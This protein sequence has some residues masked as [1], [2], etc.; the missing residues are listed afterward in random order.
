MKRHIN[1]TENTVFFDATTGFT[2]DCS[3]F[4]NGSVVFIGEDAEG[5]WAE[6]DPFTG[7]IRNV[8]SN[9]IESFFGTAKVAYEEYQKSIELTPAQIRI[10]ELKTMLAE[11]DYKDL[12]SYDKKDTSEWESLMQQR[13]AWRDEIRQL[14]N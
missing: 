3:E 6:T 8:D 9:K 4:L 7:K 11:T 1:V 12:P 2:Y 5:F 14:E 10:M 13:Q